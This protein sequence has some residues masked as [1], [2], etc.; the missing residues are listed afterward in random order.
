MQVNATE[1][2]P[3]IQMI[4]RLTAPDLTYTLIRPLGDKYGALQRQ[5]NLSVVFCLLLNRVYFIRDRHLTTAALSQTRA[6]LC[7]ILAIRALR[8]HAEN[9]L[10]LALALTTSWPVYSGAPNFLLERAREEND[11]DLEE[12]TYKRNPIHFYDPHKAPLLDHYRLKVPAIRSVL[13][14][15]N[16]VILF[17]LFVVALEY[18][19][20]DRIN[21]AE[22]IFM[23]YALGFTL[24]K[25]AAMQE[26]GI[27]VYFKGTW[28][29]FDLAFGKPIVDFHCVASHK[30]RQSPFTAR[31]Q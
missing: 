10:E 14:F 22:A 4:R 19:E 1:V 3:V 13:E 5:G 31:T 24:E 9:M 8:E 20:L 18:S 21:I 6:D 27:K 2:Y 15:M 16:F 26:H 23:I 11:D 7:E 30:D 28:N 17:I 12:R 25:V 29:G